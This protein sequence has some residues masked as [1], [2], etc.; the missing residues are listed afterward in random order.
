MA[1]PQSPA[2]SLITSV[3]L[4]ELLN[5]GV[6][7]SLQQREMIIPPPTADAGISD[8]RQVNMRRSVTK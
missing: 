8:I 1:L 6:L 7:L 4:G 3:I 5:L 2:L